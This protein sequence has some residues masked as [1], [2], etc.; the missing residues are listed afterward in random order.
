MTLLSLGKT[1]YLKLME[2]RK[3]NY[4][5]LKQQ[6]T[7][8]ATIHGERVLETKDNPISLGKTHYEMASTDISSRLSS[9]LTLQQ[10][11]KALKLQD[12]D[13]TFFGSML[14]TRCVSGTRWGKIVALCWLKLNIL[15]QQ[16][17]VSTVV[18][19]TF[20]GVTFQGFDAHCDNYGTPYLTAAAALGMEKPEVDIFITRLSKLLSQLNLQPPAQ[21]LPAPKEDEGAPQ[22]D[23]RVEE[24][25]V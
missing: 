10:V 20:H 21:S 4:I 14:F 1:G 24:G 23:G 22:A 11:Q 18:T 25:K 5:Y 6:L 7:T 13:V 9:A 15:C 12:R 19:K 8:L 2:E 3:A 17:V 16:R